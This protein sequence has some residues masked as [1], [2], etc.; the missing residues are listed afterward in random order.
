[1]EGDGSGNISAES[2]VIL[3]PIGERHGLAWAGRWKTPDY[4]HFER[5]KWRT[6]R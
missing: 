5:K 4:P 1:M 3:G 2:T 6:A